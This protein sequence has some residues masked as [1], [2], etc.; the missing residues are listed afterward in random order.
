LGRVELAVFIQGAFGISI[1][2]TRLAE[3]GTVQ[4]LARYISEHMDVERESQAT[5][6]WRS[7]L[8]PATIPSL[9]HSSLYHRAIVY[10]SRLLV[11]CLFRVKVSGNRQLPAGPFILVPNHQSYLDGLFVSAFL[12]PRI[13]LDILFYAKEQHV[14]G[15]LQ[16]FLARRSNTIVMNPSEGYLGSLQQLAAGLRRGNNL[17]IFPEGTR[18]RDGKLGPFKDAYAILAREL[19]VP[20][21]PVV[22]DGAWGVL[23]KG[24][25]FPK[26]W[27]PVSVTYLEA[28][29][30]GPEELASSFNARVRG[31]IAAQLAHRS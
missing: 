27:H 20:V 13:V 9:P 16:R 21:V 10:F 14:R 18:S 15:W 31:A 17:M 28:M 12:R 23:P 4:E 8:N 2:E 6:S 11:R 26:L 19:D 29:R 1:A 30:P 5:V 25:R 24:S 3:V 22:I 7:I